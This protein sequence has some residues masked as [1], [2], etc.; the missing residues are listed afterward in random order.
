MMTSNACS[1]GVGKAPLV[2]M[3]TLSCPPLGTDSV[4]MKRLVSYNFRSA[5]EDR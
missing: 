5:G 2:V 1:A 4:T 3:G